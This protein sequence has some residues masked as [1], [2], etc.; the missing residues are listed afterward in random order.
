MLFCDLKGFTPLVEQLGAE[1][2]DNSNGIYWWLAKD[3]VT[4]AEVLNRKGDHVNAKEYL[5]KAINIF[6]KC[7]ADGWVDRYEKNWQL[8]D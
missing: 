7:E 3:Y 6:K 8:Y 4:Y 1:D 2:A 5:S